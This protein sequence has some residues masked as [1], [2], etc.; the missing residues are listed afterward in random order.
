MTPLTVEPPV[1]AEHPEL[2]H[3]TTRA[4]VEGIWRSG[5]L[6]ATHF[7]YLNDSSEITTFHVQ[8]DEY[9]R[10]RILA[11]LKDRQRASFKIKREIDKDGGI[12]KLAQTFS[13]SICNILFT[14][15]FKN[16]SFGEGFS[17]PYISS[18]CAH[19]GD[20]NYERING[21]LS[22]WRGYGSDERYAIVFNT[23]QL[24]ALLTEEA[25]KFSIVAGFFQDV[26]YNDQNFS[27]AERFGHIADRLLAMLMAN[28]DKAANAGGPD[29]MQLDD[30]VTD[31]HLLNDVVAAATRLKHQGF[32]E[33]REVRIVTCPFTQ[34]YVNHAIQQQ[35]ISANFEASLKQIH[36]RTSAGPTEKQ[37]IPY[38]KLFDWRDQQKLP[39]ARI[40]VGPHREQSRLVTE[41]TQLTGH[42]VAIVPSATPYIGAWAKSN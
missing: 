28:I 41:I 36:Y 32:R 13:T 6:F 3:Y 12:L 25:T 42:A 26:I 8:L 15:T 31:D 16:T 21:L 22:Q 20:T 5:V 19:T 24:E 7:E 2:H 10:H 27:F 29:A 33:E 37:S 40:I 9:L 14:N 35:H 18:F 38:I 34:A 11:A 39:I 4:G 30:F 1:S 23:K 17:I